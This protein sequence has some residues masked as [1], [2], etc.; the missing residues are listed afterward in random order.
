F[1][2]AADRARCAGAVPGACA[3]CVPS[4][5]AG[6]S[7]PWASPARA[8]VAPPDAA[9]YS[10]CSSGAAAAF[11]SYAQAVRWPVP[12]TMIAIAFPLAPPGRLTISWITEPRSGVRWF[13]PA[14]PATHGTGD[15]GVAAVVR[16]RAVTLNAEEPKEKALS[17]ASAW[18]VR[19]VVT[20]CD[21][22]AANWIHAVV[23][24]AP[25]GMARLGQRMPTVW[26]Q[27][28]SVVSSRS[29]LFT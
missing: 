6:D 1:G 9:V 26:T 2:R 16:G 29:A 14:S 24:V 18:N 23:M 19:L 8:A 10:T 13:A 15:H 22:R 7:D 27:L 28:P 5:A 3:A 17:E 20:L 4:A 11:P 12:L 25:F 21:S